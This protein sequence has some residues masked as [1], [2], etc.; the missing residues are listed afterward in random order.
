[1]KIFFFCLL[2]SIA[3]VFPANIYADYVMPYPGAMPGNKLYNMYEIADAIRGWWSFGNLTQHTYHQAIA[4]KKLIEA[5]TLFE[6]KQYLLASEA[7]FAY[8]THIVLA[9]NALL[10]AA[11][12][13]KD[14]SQKKKRF[15]EA[16]LVHKSILE[17]LKNELPKEFLWQPEKDAPQML[18]IHNILDETITK[19][20]E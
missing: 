2:L 1:M 8:K 11:K 18:Q 15:Q 19:D 20:D 9:K 10:A 17:K 6:Y 14:I 4:D 12:E 3:F 7:L 5:K 16:L 13:G